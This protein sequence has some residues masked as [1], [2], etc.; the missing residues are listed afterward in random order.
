[1]NYFNFTVRVM[2]KKIFI[3]E[4]NENNMILFKAVLNTMPDLE[5]LS[6]TDGE[7]AFELIKSE[8]PDLIV[9]DIHLPGMS[10]IEICKELRKL[11]S[12][13]SSPIIAVTSF[14]LKGDKDRI[15]DAGFTKYVSKP[16]K[17]NDFRQT[18]Q[19]SLD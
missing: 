13:K 9:L 10:G 14:T 8:C 11:E 15:L 5:I 18:I 3:V 17:I 19:E 7:R 6:E 12:F 4:D 1:M 16:I 2:T